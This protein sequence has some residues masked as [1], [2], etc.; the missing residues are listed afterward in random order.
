MVSKRMLVQVKG[1]H[2]KSGDIRD[3]VGTLSRERT[4]MGVF[5]TLE[6]SAQPMIAEAAACMYHSPW[7]KKPYPKVQVLTIAELLAEENKP[8]PRCLQ[9]PGGAAEHTLPEAP[10]HT[11][12]EERGPELAFEEPADDEAPNSG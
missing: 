5:L 4:E 7:G 1:G 11:A 3:F 9:V 8:N 2:V 10:R 12:R 6:E